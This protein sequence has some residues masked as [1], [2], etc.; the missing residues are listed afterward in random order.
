ML[1]DGEF[2][3]IWEDQ[4]KT[5]F[6]TKLT[7]AMTPPA[8]ASKPAGSAPG[9]S[10]QQPGNNST[11]PLNKFETDKNYRID[12]KLSSVDD[13]TFV[14]PAEVKFMSFDTSS[15][16]KDK[17]DSGSVM[18]SGTGKP[19]MPDISPI[20]KDTTAPDIGGDE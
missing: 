16:P 18:K 13:Q 11:D 10:D 2:M 8:E 3:Y 9:S 5:G 15:M 14:P 6:K 19:A 20:S 17:V 12:C 7:P 4:A 1:N